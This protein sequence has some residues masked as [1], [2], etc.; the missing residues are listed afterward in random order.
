MAMTYNYD[1]T[2]EIAFV[3]SYLNAMPPEHRPAYPGDPATPSEAYAALPVVNWGRW[4]IGCPFCNSAQ[5]AFPRQSV[6]WCVE[7][8]NALAN[9]LWLSVRWPLDSEMVDITAALEVRPDWS[10]RNWVTGEVVTRLWGEN[11]EHQLT[12]SD[13][14]ERG[15]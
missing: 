12:P 13:F 11:I 14:R 2:D 15:Q 7:C 10:S 8:G 5:L 3:R 6:F 9:G 4:V 1:Y